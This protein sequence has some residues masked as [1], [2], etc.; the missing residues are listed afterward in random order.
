MDKDITYDFVDDV[1]REI[2]EIS[3]GPYFHIGGDE[4]LVT[5][6]E[7]FNRFMGRT[8]EIVKKYKKNPMGWY[9][10]IT[11]DI[12]EETLLQYWAKTEDFSKVI[13][14]KSKILISASS[15]SYLDMKYD[16]ITPLGLYWAGY[17]PIQKAYEWDPR[18]LVKGLDPEQIIGLEAPLWSETLEDFDDIAYMAFP[19]LIG[20]AEI[21]WT[22]ASQKTWED[23]AHRLSFHGPLLEALNVNYYPAEEINWK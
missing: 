16:S 20:H 8:L 5:P 1:I 19:R 18:T 4:S 10:L 17:V 12:P 22:K 21:G 14:K 9:E 2:S 13:P 23:Y 7:D 3:P 11:A 6:E 15:Y